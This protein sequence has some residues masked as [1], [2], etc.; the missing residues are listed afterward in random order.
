MLL[1]RATVR[2]HT[3]ASRSMSSEAVKFDFNPDV[4]LAQ[5]M[6]HCRCWLLPL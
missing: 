6:F 3:Q 5:P 4:R 2:M 1:T